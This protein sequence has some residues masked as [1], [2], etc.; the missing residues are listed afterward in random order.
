MVDVV[1]ETYIRC[2]RNI[3]AAFAADPDNAPAWY[4][5]IKSVEWETPRPLV[6]G[7]RI[8]FKV[9]FLGRQLTYTY[10]VVDYVPH[11]RSVLQT[12]EGPFPMKTT[13]IWHSINDYTTR[14]S[15]QNTGSPSGFSKI[16][17]PLFSF[18]MRLANQKD[19]DRLR[20][21]LE[22]EKTVR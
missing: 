5:N 19:L 6:K 14:M 20:K 2:P 21:I 16:V 4:V 8:L 15:L 13:Y 10:E 1:T 11:Q 22:N 12:A 18:A 3:V 7:S 17:A 9:Q